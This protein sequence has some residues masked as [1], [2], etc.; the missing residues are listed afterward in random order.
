MEFNLMKK[1]A[2]FSVIFTLTAMGVILYLSAG[3]GPARAAGA[4]REIQASL[5][6]VPEKEMQSSV[7]GEEIQNVT[8]GGARKEDPDSP[9]SKRQALKFVQGEADTSY[10]RIPLPGECGAEDILIE[11]YYMDQELCILIRTQEKNFYAEN[12]ISGNQEMVREGSFEQEEDS[13][14]LLLGLT[15]IFECQ[16]ILEDN[17]LYVN[18]FAPR[19]MYD[20]IVVID[21]ACGGFNTG[22]EEGDFVEKDINLQITR[23]LK[24]KLD[25]TDIKAYYTRMDD[26]NPEEKD[27]VRLA[28]E[29]RAD[30]YI[31]IQA[32]TNDDSGV[33]GTSALYNSDYFI[34]GFGSVELADLLEREVVTSIKGKALGLFEAGNSEYAIR[35]VTVPAAALKAGCATNSQEAGLLKREEYQEKIADG[36]CNAIVKAYEEIR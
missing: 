36:I 24:E 1:A 5:S 29:I 26:V 13:V 15:G 12:A 4:E 25:E 7:E 17:D 16:T 3:R 18:F 10:L 19:E 8:E 33:Y 11:N 31:R 20:K 35:H 34:P 23:K 2:I 30:M 21:A 14:Q 27:R 32:D 6:K 9:E 28:N 22:Y